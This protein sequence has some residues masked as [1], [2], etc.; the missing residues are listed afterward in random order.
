MAQSF[1]QKVARRIGRDRCIKVLQ[2]VNQFLRKM[3][4][5]SH[6]LQMDLQYN[7]RPTP[8]WFDHFIDVHYLWGR[9]QNPLWL[10][11]G[12]YS[13]L[14]MKRGCEVLEICCGDGFFAKYFYSGIAKKIVSVDF[15][16]VAIIHAKKNHQ[17]RNIEFRLV[18]IRKNMPEGKFDNIIWDAAIEHFTEKEIDATLKNIKKR[19]R[20][21]AILNG[22]TI[23]ERHD[24]QKSLE[25]HEY[26]FKSKEDL[27]RFFEPYFKN[28]KVFEVVYPQ[29]HSLFFWA[30]DG[31]LPFDL[32][33]Q[34]QIISQDKNKTQLEFT[35]AANESSTSF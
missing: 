29:R 12:V 20:S 11:R 14:G 22:H 19:M 9:H 25:Q 32:N 3:T 23:V 33:W 7:L 27:L 2:S 34:S 35:G 21:E 18:D 8:E 4:S 13:A 5:Q 15:D 30:S 24:G 17:A 26:E 6:A 1:I 31:I 10:E 16:E 28:V